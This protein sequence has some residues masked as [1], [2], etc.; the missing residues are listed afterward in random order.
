MDDSDAEESKMGMG[1]EASG[2]PAVLKGQL[3]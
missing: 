3:P 2:V 1:V